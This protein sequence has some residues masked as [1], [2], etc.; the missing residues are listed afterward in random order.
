MTW[1]LSSILIGFVVCGSVPKENDCICK[2]VT[3]KEMTYCGFELRDPN[4]YPHAVYMCPNG[5]NSKAMKGRQCHSSPCEL[6]DDIAN[7]MD[8]TE[9]EKGVNEVFSNLRYLINCVYR[10]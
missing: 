9:F 3:K 7:C 2:I 6:A 5:D 4:C 1:V 10:C 8:Y